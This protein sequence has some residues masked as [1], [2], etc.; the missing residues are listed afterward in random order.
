MVAAEVRSPHTVVVGDWSSLI[1]G[2]DD[3]WV[4]ILWCCKGGMLEEKRFFHKL[5][6]MIT[7]P[8]IKQRVLATTQESGLC[9]VSMKIWCFKI[10]KPSPSRDRQKSSI[11]GLID[12][13]SLSTFLHRNRE[14]SFGNKVWLHAAGTCRYCGRDGSAVDDRS[15][16]RW[17]IFQTFLWSWFCFCLEE[18][19]KIRC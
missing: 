5:V 15:V 12:S 6:L 3:H 10:R 13:Q 18:D 1:P 7:S 4:N 14:C 11:F 2:W 9:C 17:S 19:E 8:L 16:F